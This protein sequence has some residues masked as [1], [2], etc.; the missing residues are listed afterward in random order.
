MLLQENFYHE[1][2]QLKILEILY[3]RPNSDVPEE[4]L[5]SKSRNISLSASRTFCS[6]FTKNQMKLECSTFLADQEALPV[7]DSGYSQ[8][9]YTDFGHSNLG[10]PK[11]N[12]Y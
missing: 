11:F 8:H 3:F 1:H 5:A 9:Q 4:Y 10:V 12:P 6:Y 7:V 2:Q